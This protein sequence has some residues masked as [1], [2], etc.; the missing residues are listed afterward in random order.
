MLRLLSALSVLLLMPV[1]SPASRQTPA[2]SPL[3]ILA[4]GAHPDDAE[5]KASGVAALWAAPR[6]PVLF[7]QLPAA[8]SLRPSIVV[9][10][11]S[12]AEQKWVCIAAMPS[13]FVDKDS[14]QARTKPGVPS[15]DAE[16]LAFL[17]DGVKARSAGVADQYRERLLPL[18]GDARGRVKYAEAFQVNQYGRSASEEELK[19]LFPTFR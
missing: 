1:V 9:G 11:D 16:R 8:V 6:V 2:T 3:R 5:L 15:G 13:Q 7:R 4:F 17:L 12:V 10:I 19:G 14:R 18:Y